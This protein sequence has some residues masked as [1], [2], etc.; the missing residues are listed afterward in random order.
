LVIVGLATL[1]TAAA[2]A[3]Y[4]RVRN[5]D[6]SHRIAVIPLIAVASDTARDLWPEF[7]TDELRTAI[8]ERIAG[9]PGVTQINSVSADHFRGSTIDL[10]SV[11]TTLDADRVVQ[12][13][14]NRAGADVSVLVE[15]VNTA[16]KTARSWRYRHDPTDP[17]TRAFAARVAKD[18]IEQ[19]LNLTTADAGAVRHQATRAALDAYTRGTVI[20]NQL[21]TKADLERAIAY[22]EAAV[23]ADSAFAQPLARIALAYQ[24]ASGL[25]GVPAS[26]A[27]PAAE[28]AARRAVDLDHMN[29][30]AHATLGFAIAVRSWS[31]ADARQELQT[32]IDLDPSSSV[33]HG[34]LGWLLAM[35]GDLHGALREAHE[36]IRLDPFQLANHFQT[37][38]WN[39]ALGRP[40]SAIAASRRKDAYVPG[41]EMSPDLGTSDAFR[42]A[43]N[44]DRALALDSATAK[45]L[46][47]PTAPLV[48]SLERK[49]LHAQAVSA[50]D[51][52]V[53]ASRR[54][55]VAPEHLARAANAIG[56]RN[57]TLAWLRE[58]KDMHSDMV[59][60]FRWFPDMRPL[61]DDPEYRKLL[62]EMRLPTEPARK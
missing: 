35:Q 56:D 19:G 1:L 2:G 14:F 59:L 23:R 47:R 16:D 42:E 41:I 52:L 45:E 61:L 62:D 18:V 17:E 24:V 43:G 57:A 6:V 50:Y 10:E 49:G 54:Q 13:A 26:F 3:Y 27:Y 34:N 21:N 28:R 58:A 11:R 31:W 48:I 15:L 53:A 46:G 7:I 22:F 29:A 55:F 30:E 33:A 37:I 36:A 60:F 8:G 4:V 20:A 5:G 51:S 39:L 32:A 25:D 12:L 9:F 40:D 44:V 38:F